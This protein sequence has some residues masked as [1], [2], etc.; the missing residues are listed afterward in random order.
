MNFVS[1]GELPPGY[2]IVVPS[3][4]PIQV[5]DIKSSDL[6]R[7][8]ATSARSKSEYPIQW[9]SS[10]SVKALAREHKKTKERIEELEKRFLEG[11]TGSVK[12][13]KKLTKSRS[14]RKS[15]V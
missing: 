8:R 15:V 2:E 9:S 6:I 3:E 1:H 13:T 4:E 10:G 5:A 7:R 12:H 11:L 14:D